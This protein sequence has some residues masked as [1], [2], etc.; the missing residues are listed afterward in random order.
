MAENPS[1]TYLAYLVRLWREDAHTWRA[2]VEDPHTGERHTFASVEALLAYLKEQTKRSF[3][4][5][6]S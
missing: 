6:E 2:S 4:E 5:E 3:T 1:P